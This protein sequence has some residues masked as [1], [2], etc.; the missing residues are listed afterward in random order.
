[1]GRQISPPAEE[2]VTYFMEPSET[3]PLTDECKHYQAKHEVPWDIQKYFAQ[4]YSI[5]SLYESGVQLTDDAWF[6]VTP[7]PVARRIAQQMAGIDKKKRVLIDA[8]AGAGGNTIAFALT[9]RWDRII[10]IERDSATLACA[11]NNAEVYGVDSSVVTWVHGDSFQYFDALL[12]RPETLHPD[13]RS[14]IPTT[15]V[16]ASPPW[17]GPG[18]RTDKIFDLTKMQP[19]SILQLWRAYAFMDHALFLPRT[20]DLRQISKL[21]PKGKSVKGVQYCM[22][23]ASKGMVAY[24]PARQRRLA[25]ELPT[26]AHNGI[27]RS[28]EKSTA[29]DAATTARAK[30]PRMSNGDRTSSSVDTS[31]ALPAASSK[32]STKRLASLSDSSSSSSD[33]SDSSDTSEPASPEPSKRRSAS[34]NDDTSSSSDSSEAA[35]PEPPNE[36]LA[37]VGD[38]LL[39]SSS[40]ASNAASPEL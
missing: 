12:K 35:S 16:F 32:S 4:R 24:V 34:A 18:Y 26:S 2:A 36:R 17:G 40:P 21:A 23:G 5:F 39:L 31:A 25:S 9:Q 30:K 28:L 13:L 38:V 20:S 29:P 33:S 27:K 15:V 8:F 6:G 22:W 19:Y 14:D 3:L 10:A 1:M 11:Q 7:E 37:P